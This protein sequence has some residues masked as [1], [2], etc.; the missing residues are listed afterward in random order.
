[1]AERGMAEY[2]RERG[3]FMQRIKALEDRADYLERWAA[4]VGGGVLLPNPPALQ[5]RRITSLSIP[6]NTETIVTG[7]TNALAEEGL[8]LEDGSSIVKLRRDSAVE[9]YAFGIMAVFEANV[10]NNRAL[11][12]EVRD[13]NAGTWATQTWLRVPA[14][15]NGLNSILSTAIIYRMGETDDAVRF[16]VKQDSGGALNLTLFLLNAIIVKSGDVAAA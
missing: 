10:T 14:A 1:M 8:E 5:G 16:K 3:N 11:L 15:V 4:P 12:I 2:D 7:L 9:W 13:I 6:N